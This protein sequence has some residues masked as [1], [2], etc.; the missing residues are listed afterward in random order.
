MEII[1]VP[2]KKPE[3][4]NM[5]I[6]QAH[7]IKTVEDLYETIVSS[8]AEMRFGV[9]FCEASGACKVRVEGNDEELKKIAGQAALDLSAGHTFVVM[10]RKGFPINVLNQ[11]KSLSE[12]CSVFAATA[13]PLEVIVADSEK[14]RGVLGV[15]DGSKPNGVETDEDVRWRKEFLRKIGYKR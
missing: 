7:F 14:G 13:N 2:I 4:V 1:S 10:M 6:G 5:I 11:I 3:D 12:V 9:A 8:S 15:I